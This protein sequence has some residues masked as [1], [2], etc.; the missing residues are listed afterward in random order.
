VAAPLPDRLR[1]E[2]LHAVEF[3]LV[4]KHLLHAGLW[5]TDRSDCS[6]EPSSGRQLWVG[7]HLW[8]AVLDRPDKPRRRPSH[9]PDGNYW[10]RRDLE[11]HPGSVLYGRLRFDYIANGR[12]ENRRLSGLI[13]RG[14]WRERQMLLQMPRNVT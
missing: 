10:L 1:P 2:H 9:D 3:T 4:Q 14:Q 6:Q 11:S 7:R 5:D 8:H 13:A 12:R